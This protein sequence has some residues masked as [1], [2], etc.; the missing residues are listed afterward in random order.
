ML[1]SPLRFSLS[2]SSSLSLPFAYIV[3]H[4]RFSPPPS[5]NHLSRSYIPLFLCLTR[6]KH[7][8]TQ[9]QQSNCRQLAPPKSHPYLEGR[10]LLTTESLRPILFT[11]AVQLHKYYCKQPCEMWL[12]TITNLLVNSHETTAPAILVL[13]CDPILQPRNFSPRLLS[14]PASLVVVTI[15]LTAPLLRSYDLIV[16]LCYVPGITSYRFNPLCKS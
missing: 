3:A 4:S 6:F 5:L 2:L 7:A 1:K 8:Y 14:N 16:L 13:S 15:A 11:V 10:S 12:Y 9:L